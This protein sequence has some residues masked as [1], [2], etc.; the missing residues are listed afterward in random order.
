VTAVIKDMTC[1]IF[2]YISNR[3]KEVVKDFAV[4]MRGRSPNSFTCNKS[5]NGENHN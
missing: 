4:A 2:I 5:P 3:I 1:V